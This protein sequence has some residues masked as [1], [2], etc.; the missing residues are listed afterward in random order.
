MNNTITTNYI[1]NYILPVLT[2]IQQ[3]S[4]LGSEGSCFDKSC[5]IFVTS[6]E[7]WTKNQNTCKGKGGD[8]VSMETEEEWEYIN[9]EIQ[10]LLLPKENEWHIGLKDEGD[11]KWVSGNPLTIKKWQSGQPSGDGKFAVMSKDYPPGTQGLFNDLPD[12]IPR[13][14]ICEIPKGKTIRK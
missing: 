6:G 3:F 13:A 1:V 9:S 4:L 12:W 5:Y 10:Q 14:F 8:L 7:T 2:R 11:W